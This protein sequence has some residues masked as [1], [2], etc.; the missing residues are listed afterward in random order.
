MSARPW[1]TVAERNILL[2]LMELLLQAMDEEN[3]A[4]A[5]NLDD[6]WKDF[7]EGDDMDVDSLPSVDSNDPIEDLDFGEEELFDLIRDLIWMTVVYGEFILEDLQSN[8][9]F[10]TQHLQIHHLSE[11]KCVDDF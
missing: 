2:D 8:V 6:Y 5:D 7:W 1:N 9:Q 4:E 11:V 3:V 10:N